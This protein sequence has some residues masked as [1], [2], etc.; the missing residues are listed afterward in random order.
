MSP[1][2]ISQPPPRAGEVA[3]SVNARDVTSAVASKNVFIF[4][5]RGQ[6]A[7]GHVEESPTRVSVQKGPAS[8]AY[9]VIPV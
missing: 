7:E 4:D 8:L 6:A 5:P 3:A 1:A 2:P 9:A